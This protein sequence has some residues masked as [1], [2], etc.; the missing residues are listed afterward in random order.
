M[1]IGLENRQKHP[2]MLEELGDVVVVWFSHARRLPLEGA[3]LKFCLEIFPV[4]VTQ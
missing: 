1:H 3:P 4:L 2:C